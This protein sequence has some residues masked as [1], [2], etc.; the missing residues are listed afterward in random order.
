MFFSRVLLRRRS[1]LPGF[2]LA[3]GMTVLYLS[4]IVLIPL[5]AAFF[6]TT[7]LTWP[8]FIETVT[9]PRVVAS[10]K[11]TF[12]ASIAGCGPGQRRVWFVGG[13]GTGAAIP[14]LVAVSLTPWWTCL[15]PCLPLWR[16]S[17]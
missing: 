5:S 14:S 4:L 3:L 2:D 10:Y 17:P 1:V 11:L 7:E 13:L 9:S 12:G 15:L 6:R 8:Q 16:A